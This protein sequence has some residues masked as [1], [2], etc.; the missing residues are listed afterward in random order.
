MWHIGERWSIIW[1][2]QGSPKHG[3]IMAPTY[4]IWWLEKTGFRRLVN[5]N[6]K[7]HLDIFE[8]STC[9]KARLIRRMI[10]QI[11]VRDLQC[12]TSQ[13][14]ETNLQVLSIS[15]HLKQREYEPDRNVKYK[16][17][18]K[19]TSPHAYLHPVGLRVQSKNLPLWD[20]K[21]QHLTGTCPKPDPLS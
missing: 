15:P 9:Y 19:E 11:S 14:W 17:L 18:P 10:L 1:E 21:L 12:Q 3:L 16:Y 13:Q 5:F 20:N 4:R 7:C 8:T 2:S 6:L